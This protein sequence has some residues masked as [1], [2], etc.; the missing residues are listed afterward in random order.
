MAGGSAEP[1]AAG[2]LTWALC[3]LTRLVLLRP[4]LTLALVALSAIVALAI[5]ARFLSFKTSRSDLID[6]Q[7]DFQQRW[8]RYVERFGEQSDLVI[9]V[10]ADDPAIVRQ[11]LDEVGTQMEREPDLFDRVHWKFEPTS[12][13]RKGLQYLSPTERTTRGRPVRP[14]TTRRS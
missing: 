2:P 11:A 6:P 3:A 13:A 14:A 9:V 12:L 4:G 8:L 7:A 1:R 10:E 5:G